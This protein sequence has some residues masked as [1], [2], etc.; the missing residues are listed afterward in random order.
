MYLRTGTALW[1]VWTGTSRNTGGADPA[2]RSIG[3]ASRGYTFLS[4]SGEPKARLSFAELDLRARAVAVELGRLTRPGDRA[5]LHYEP[6]LDFLVGFFGCL[7]AG[8]IAV[9]AAPLEGTLADSATAS[10][11]RAILRS[12]DPDVVLTSSEDAGTTPALLAR[13]GWPVSP[14]WTPTS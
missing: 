5:L 4:G 1:S 2:T 10:R 7:Y 6:G 9:P 3:D 13:R 8:V 11:L 12:A 14:G